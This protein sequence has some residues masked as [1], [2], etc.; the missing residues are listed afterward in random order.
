MAKRRWVEFGLGPRGGSRDRIYVS[1]TPGGVLRLNGMAAD[2]LGRPEAVVLMID[3]PTG[4]I[5][6]RPTSPDMPNAYRA[7]RDRGSSVRLMCRSL[8]KENDIKLPS[9]V[10]FPTARV[11]DGVLILELKYHVPLPKRGRS[12]GRET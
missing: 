3:P 1:L 7:G 12:D 11:E 8:L 6:L 2:A 9:T 10:T 4:A 5:G